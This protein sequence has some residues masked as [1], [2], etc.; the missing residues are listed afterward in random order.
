VGVGVNA[1]LPQ[2]LLD[3]GVPEVLDLVIGSAGQLGG[4]LRPSEVKKEGR[5][6]SLISKLIN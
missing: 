1:S 6:R 5:V 2:F 3:A 4:N